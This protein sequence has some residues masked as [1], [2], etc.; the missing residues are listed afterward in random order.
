MR[1]DECEWH[2]DKRRCRKYA[3]CVELTCLTYVADHASSVTWPQ[4][5]D[6]DW[7]G[8][9]QAKD[10]L[11]T[12]DESLAAIE[13][14]PDTPKR[15][16]WDFQ[17]QKCGCAWMARLDT[18]PGCGCSVTDGIRR[19][20]VGASDFRERIIRCC[21]GTAVEIVAGMIDGLVDETIRVER[22]ACATEVQRMTIRIEPPFIEQYQQGLARS[23]LGQVVAAI[24]NH[25]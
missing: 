12:L 1:C 20:E 24:R 13:A 9:F 22:D 19:D 17:C 3:P 16:R 18:C 8:E 14:K 7:C 25:K 11:P 2:D 15:T 4:T 6:D 21:R 23:I 10:S 5:E